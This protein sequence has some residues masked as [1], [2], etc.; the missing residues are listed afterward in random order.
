[1]Q[2]CSN[3]FFV[4]ISKPKIS[5][6]PINVSLLCLFDFLAG[7]FDSSYCGPAPPVWIEMDALIFWTIQLKMDP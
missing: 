1:M 4:K 6:R 3:E 7:L 5:S 2:S